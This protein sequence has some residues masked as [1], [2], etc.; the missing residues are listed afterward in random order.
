VEYI[1][2]ESFLDKRSAAEAPPTPPESSWK[3]PEAPRSTSPVSALEALPPSLYSVA[4]DQRP[5]SLFNFYNE[6]ASNRVSVAQDAQPRDSIFSYYRPDAGAAPGSK[7]DSLP[8]KLSRKT[9]SDKR[10][11]LLSE[12][13]F[14]DEP[15]QFLP[16]FSMDSY[17]SPPIQEEVEDMADHGAVEMRE[18]AILTFLK[19]EVLFLENIDGILY[20]LESIIKRRKVAGNR[21]SQSLAASSL[22]ITRYTQENDELSTVLNVLNEIKTIHTDLSKSIAE[23][24]FVGPSLLAYSNQILKPLIKY[25]SL[26]LNPTSAIAAIVE[27]YRAHSNSPEYFEISEPLTQIE[28]YGKVIRGICESSALTSGFRGD[29]LIARMAGIKIDVIHRVVGAN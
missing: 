28:G 23:D 13:S 22:D 16:D 21:A 20:F 17:A 3:Y 11:S 24:E 29:G 2:K 1:P 7:E 4:T 9:T 8:A 26:V 6:E 25:T 5:Y 18:T 15:V 12:M 27:E 19:S 10:K 14:F